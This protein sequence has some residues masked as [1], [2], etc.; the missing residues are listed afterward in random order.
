MLV[1]AAPF[2]PTYAQKLGVDIERL[3]VG[4]PSTGRMALDSKT[5]FLLY[6]YTYLFLHCEILFIVCQPDNR[7]MSL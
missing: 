5:I 1:D 7:D 6:P 3:I 2:H 4:Q